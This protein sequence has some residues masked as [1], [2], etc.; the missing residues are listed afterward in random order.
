MAMHFS[1]HRT[2]CVVAWL[3]VAE[4][5]IGD[6][7]PA[8]AQDAT[9]KG[10]VKPVAIELAQAEAPAK[11]E[12]S[13]DVP[14]PKKADVLRN[15]PSKSDLLTK[16]PFDWV[17]LKND[18]VLTVKPLQ[19]RPKTLDQ[20]NE[21][22]KQMAQ[23]PKVTRMAGESQEAFA[24]RLRQSADEHRKLREKV[25]NIEVELPDSTKVSED[26][27]DSSYKLNVDKYVG[28][29]I[30]FEDVVLRRVDLLLDNA[31]LEDAYELLLFVDRRHLGWPGYDERLNRF[32]L[33]DAQGK[34]AQGETE[35]AFALLEQMHERVKSAINSKDPLVRYA[36]MGQDL[37]KCSTELGKAIDILVE[38][39][40]KSRDFRQ[41]RFYLSRM[42]KLQSDH[43]NAANWRDQLIAETNRL[44]A[45]AATATAAGKFDQAAVLADEAALVWPATPSLKNSHRQAAQ[46][47]QILK[48]GSIDPVIPVTRFPFATEATRRRDGLNRLQFFEPS[49]I[50]GGA[51]YRSRFL[52]SWEPTDLG[53]QAVF[54]LR[55]SR[56]SWESSPIVTAS[57]V[58]TAL[59]ERLEPSSAHFDERLASFIDGVAVSGPFEFSVKFS[60]IPVRTEALFAMPLGTSEQTSAELDQRYRVATVGDNAISLRRTVNEPERVLQRHLAEILEYRYPSHE[61]A[62]QGLLRGEISMIPCVPAWQL[63]KLAADGRFFVRKYAVPQTHFVQFNPQSKPLRSPE[64]R[65]ALLY[66]LDRS[67]VLRDVMLRDLTVRTLRESLPKAKV[68]AKLPPDSGLTYDEAKSELVWTGMA[69][70]DQQSRQFTA[71]SFDVDYRKSLQTLVKKSQPDR[72]RVVTA[73]WA[74]SLSAYHRLVPPREADMSLAFALATAA[75]KS[76]GA[77]MRTLRMICEP[78]PIVEDAAKRLIE[79]WKRIDINIELVSLVAPAQAAQPPGAAPLPVASGQDA[80]AAPAAAPQPPTWDLVY[81]TSRM[82]EPMM[83]LWPLLSLDTVSRVESIRY[84]PDW[85][86]QGLIDLDRVADWATTVASLQELHRELS[87]T[88]QFIPLWEI[89]DALVFRKTLRGIPEAPLHP[90]H[91]V[92]QWISEP[93]YPID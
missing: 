31:E 7:T 34:L 81:R 2:Q 68:P 54:T 15:L 62:V 11:A 42:I 39:A 92:E 46:R 9:T 28:D 12:Q 16:P 44:L 85:L 84:L 86:R 26:E 78:D 69:I 59:L 61:K 77:E 50:D 5:L 55:S 33:L 52:E 76:L 65:R 75:K 57:G 87:E 64:L 93:W 51:R 48:V 43:P 63:D 67:Q 91:D 66:G 73:P 83:E 79:D 27:E 25:D 14:L 41:A 8:M 56:S 13:T 4:L 58:V 1:R 60:R 18:D 80:V 74:T 72:G 88:V 40:V 24:A 20:I 29:I 6:A 71:L 89:D 10:S 23:P 82:T 22:R 70:T 90:Y 38:P 35:T 3:F 53:R 17:F 21:K 37:A 49:R 19:P 32:L 47:W 45:E 30:N 36:T